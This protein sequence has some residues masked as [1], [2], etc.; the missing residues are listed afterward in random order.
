[1]PPEGVPSSTPVDASNSPLAVQSPSSPGPDTPASNLRV[2]RR[3]RWFWIV[4]L[5]LVILAI[6][7]IVRGF[8][9]GP[10]KA[11]PRAA[12]AVDV[13]Q[14]KTGAMNVYIE[15][16]GT[17]TPPHTV[18]VYSQITGRLTE[19]YYRQ[20]QM[21]HVGEP[22]VEIDPRPYQ[23][24]LTQAEGS[25]EHDLGLLA[26]ARMDLKTYEAAYAR[27]AIAKQQLD[28]QEKLVVQDEGSVKADQGTVAYDQ[29]QLSYCHIVAPITGRVG[30][31]LVDPGNTV[32]AGSGSTLVVVTQLQPITV[33]FEVAEDD[34]P[35]VEAQLRVRPRMK[36][37]AYDRGDQK[38]IETGTLEALDNE[39][40]TTTGTVKFRADFANRNLKLFPNQFVNTRLLV[41][42][43]KNVTLVPSAAVQYNGTS[44]FVYV[45]KPDHTVAVQPTTVLNSNE[46]DTAVTG[47]N[48][49]VA[50]V[51]SGFERIENGS[52]VEV[53]NQPQA[54]AEG[55]GSGSAPPSPAQRGP[56]AN[57]APKTS[58]RK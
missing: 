14:S 55:Q 9:G 10:K 2:R 17:V 44:A 47:L 51:T 37:D 13:G 19:V 20:G 41:N 24:T 42:T 29:T 34:L 39:V 28:D 11:P 53:T 4:V 32:F 40:D 48:S 7:F 46:S 23:A 58:S 15:A 6:F 50:V 57:R 18:T 54:P 22:L 1:M 16:L 31:R 56:S 38:L 12:A 5:A 27:N 43:L 3:H 36:V 25:L 35:Q 21:V 52:H 8:E 33:V 26:Q 49:G 30:L 45:V